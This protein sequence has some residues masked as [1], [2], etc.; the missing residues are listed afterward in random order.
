MQFNQLML[1]QLQSEAKYLIL[2]C[3]EVGIPWRSSDLR[4]SAS[5]AEGTG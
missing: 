3:F 4:L 5:T 2:N 1:F